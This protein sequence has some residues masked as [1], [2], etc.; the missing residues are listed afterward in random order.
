MNITLF[1]NLTEA[2]NKLLDKLDSWLDSIILNLPN[3]TL[4]LLAFIFAYIAARLIKKGMLK[5]LNRFSKNGAINRLLS[6]LAAALVVSIGIF[7]ALG[8]LNL[9]KALTSLLAGAGVVGLAIGLAFQEPIMNGVSGMII[10]IRETYKIGNIIET[11]G[12]TGTIKKISLRETTIEQFSGEIVI[13]PNKMILHNPIK[14]YST[15]GIQRVNLQC[16]VGYGS[17]LEEV[18]ATALTAIEGIHDKESGKEPHIFFEAF[19]DSSI[20]FE[21]NY[22][23]CSDH[24]HIYRTALSE[25]MIALKKAFDGKGINIPFPIRTLDF[26]MND[27]KDLTNA[28]SK[29]FSTISF[30]ENEATTGNATK[31][32]S[33]TSTEGK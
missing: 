15:S 31:G 1:L 11:N 23:V 22:W 17:N 10:A 20:N 18:A 16:G 21:L 29:S 3:F 9:D 6:K 32:D 24:A 13:V 26:G 7:I 27:G 12:I 4:A 33:N 8:I 14:N 2:W 28:L 19:G 25:G 30:A 5:V